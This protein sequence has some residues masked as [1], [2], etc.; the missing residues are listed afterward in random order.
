MH[1]VT[2]PE[3]PVVIDTTGEEVPASVRPRRT[4]NPSIPAAT[5]RRA[6]VV[7]FAS[8]LRRLAPEAPFWR[9]LA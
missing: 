3:E 8:T 1:L 7:P 6:D 5:Q 4:E 2:P 9:E